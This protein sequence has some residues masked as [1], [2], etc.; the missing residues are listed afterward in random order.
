MKN[1]NDLNSNEWIDVSCKHCGKMFC[2]LF[3]YPTEYCFAC[4]QY[5]DE[6]KES[7]K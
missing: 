4:K 3:A 1:F 7:K 5:E 6:E 2:T